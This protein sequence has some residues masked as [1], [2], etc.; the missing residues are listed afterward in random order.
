[1]VAR[2]ACGWWLK[3]T[4]SPTAGSSGLGGGAVAQPAGDVGPHLTVGGE[5]DEGAAVLD[6]DPAGQQAG[7]GKRL[8]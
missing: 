4:Q 1:M 7:I 8:E 2:S 3:A 6:R 5:E